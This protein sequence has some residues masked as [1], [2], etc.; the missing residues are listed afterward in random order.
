M[1]KAGQKTY[2]SPNIFDNMCYYRLFIDS[3][4]CFLAEIFGLCYYAKYLLMCPTL[5]YFCINLALDL[6]RLWN[7]LSGYD[8]GVLDMFRG[9]KLSRLFN[10]QCTL[11]PSE[12]LILDWFQRSTD[13][14]S[15]QS[16]DI[17]FPKARICNALRLMLAIGGGCRRCGVG[18]A[19]D[20][21]NDPW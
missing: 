7:P 8:E 3:I 16:R 13:M 14:S 15:R 5:E 11:W 12:R 9:A 4:V 6:L 18:R 17:R 2:D 20:F 19:G 21:I 10:G 1:L